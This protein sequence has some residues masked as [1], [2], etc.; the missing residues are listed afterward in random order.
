LLTSV[1]LIAVSACTTRQ[2]PTASSPTPIRVSAACAFSTSPTSLSFP[3]NG[4][5]QIVT[6]AAAPSGCAPSTWTAASADAGLTFAP[7]AGDG[8]GFVTVTAAANTGSAVTD[9]ATIAGQTLT[10]N[11]AAAPIGPMP[12]PP[13]PTAR[14]RMLT[15]TLT[16]GEQLSGPWAGTVAALNGY[17]CTLTQRDVTVTCPA[18]AVEDG[19]SVDLLVTLAPQLANLGFP[20]RKATGCDALTANVCRV[21]MNADRSVTISIGWSVSPGVAKSP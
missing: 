1:G 9:T 10:V 21:L 4:G 13:P 5:S 3:S 7:T 2:T 14:Q 20:I 16:H 18:L 8:N 17:S 6:V 19:T 12:P 15:V 11:L